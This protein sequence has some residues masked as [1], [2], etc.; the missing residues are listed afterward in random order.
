M[1]KNQINNN[2]IALISRGDD[3]QKHASA[4]RSHVGTKVPLS[5]CRGSFRRSESSGIV[6]ELVYVQL[7][8]PTHLRRTRQSPGRTSAGETAKVFRGS[9]DYAVGSPLSS[10]VEAQSVRAIEGKGDRVVRAYSPVLSLELGS[11]LV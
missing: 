6:G 10:E 8:I 3:V 11:E 1:P 9:T 2:N 4:L 5:S 7:T